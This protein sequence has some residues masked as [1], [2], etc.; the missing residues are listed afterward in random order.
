MVGVFHMKDGIIGWKDGSDIFLFGL[1][2]LKN[3]T[4]DA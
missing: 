2:L 3:R 4:L 1:E